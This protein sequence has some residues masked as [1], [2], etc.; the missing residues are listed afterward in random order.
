MS[1]HADR[2]TAPHNPSLRL[3]VGAYVLGAL[4]PQESDEVAAHL[5]ACPGC[6]EEYRQSRDLVPLL[7][8]VTEADAV[9]GPPA[10]DADMLGQTLA[11]WRRDTAGPHRPRTDRGRRPRRPRQAR[12]TLAAVCLVL[13]AADGAVM[14]HL[15]SGH[16]AAVQA[17]WSATAT[18][19]SADADAATAT[20][21]VSPA[22]W[23]SAIELTITDVP[24]GYECT[25]VVVA[26]DGHQETAGT[27]K[28]PASGE[29]TIP[30]TVG[31]D[32]GAIASIKVRLPDGEDLV[33]LE[34]P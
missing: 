31:L 1:D 10:P 23:G 17:A 32:P 18:A 34:R 33:T 15:A 3:A 27:W 28:A 25:M 19:S 21:R 16:H 13:L 6:R 20:V 9:H 29:V 4:D 26:S 5:A 7:A 8:A 12:Y 22:A 2:C 11:A 30:G 14:T 24:R